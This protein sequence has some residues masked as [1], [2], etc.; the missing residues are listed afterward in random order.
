MRR[1]AGLGDL[2]FALRRGAG[3]A[4]W[5]LL[6]SS[7]KEVGQD[8]EVPDCFLSVCVSEGLLFDEANTE[9]TA[10]FRTVDDRTAMFGSTDR[11]TLGGRLILPIRAVA[12]RR[13][14][15][16]TALKHGVLAP[17]PQDSWILCSVFCSGDTAPD[18]R[19]AVGARGQ[20]E[21]LGC[22][23]KAGR[24]IHLDELDVRFVRQRGLTIRA[25]YHTWQCLLGVKCISGWHG[26]LS[27]TPGEI[28]PIMSAKRA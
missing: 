25:V 3:H 23:E 28:S 7:P 15:C 10:S 13:R 4:T 6:L 27:P 17:V 26:S 21:A 8:S 24:G 11:K 18:G 19:A 9:S 12:S 14:R 20:V 2:R 16:I 22:R 5:P 1:R